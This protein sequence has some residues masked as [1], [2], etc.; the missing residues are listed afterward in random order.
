VTDNLDAFC[1]WTSR[2]A[3][4][5]RD[6]AHSFVPFEKDSRHFVCSLNR[7]LPNIHV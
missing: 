3:F 6:T 1:Q 2:I 4:Q 7:M 5:V